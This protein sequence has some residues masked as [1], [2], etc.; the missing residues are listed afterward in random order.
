MRVVGNGSIGEGNSAL[1]IDAAA[2]KGTVVSGDRH[3]LDGYPSL[4]INAAPVAITCI[5]RGGRLVAGDRGVGDRNTAGVKVD[6]DAAAVALGG[7]VAGDGA[8]VHGEAALLTHIYA[9]ATAV[10]RTRSVIGNGSAMHGEARRVG[11]IRRADKEHTAAGAAACF[12]T[13]NLSTIHGKGRAGLI[14]AALYTDLHA[15]GD[16]AAVQLKFAAVDGHFALNLSVAGA[17]SQRQ[18]RAAADGD[19][20]VDRLPVQAEVDLAVRWHS[21][22]LRHGL[23]QIIAARRIRQGIG[24]CPL[25]ASSVMFVPV[26]I[27]IPAADAVVGMIGL[28]Q[29][30]RSQ[31]R[32]LFSKTGREVCILRRADG[33]VQIHHLLTASVGADTDGFLC[34]FAG[35]EIRIFRRTDR[36]VGIDRPLLTVGFAAALRRSIPGHTGN[37]PTVLGIALLAGI[38]A[39]RP[40]CGRNVAAAFVML[41]AFMRTA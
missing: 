38:P 19:F 36:T 14:G 2:L 37:K 15:A 41:A 12:I 28:R 18:L 29:R 40:L 13:G 22:V 20:A 8:A 16:R 30:K 10:R 27:S 17:V 24:S 6:I 33:T 39:G 1:S 21:P 31:R 35:R 4:R 25:C 11:R 3:I 34:A 32:R 23:R 9:A 7:C 26:D 5:P